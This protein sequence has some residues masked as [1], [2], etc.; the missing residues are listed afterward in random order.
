MP[1]I[2]L[3]DTNVL[4]YALAGKTPY[5]TLFKKLLDD[6]RLVM[7]AV[8]VAE[9]LSGAHKDEELAFKNI[10]ESV[11]VLPVDGAVAQIAASYRREF[12]RKFKKVWLTDCM[13]AATC[14]VFGATLVTFDP[15]DY[16]MTD[17][18]VKVD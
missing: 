2:Y 8:V 5:S 14:K 15:K 7:S 13:I 4:I 10:L 17:I 3:P 12:K 11:E 18:D 1:K 16:P 6:K 9:F